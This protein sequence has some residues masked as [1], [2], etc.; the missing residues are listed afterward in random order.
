MEALLFES[1]GDAVA[2]MLNDALTR[3]AARADWPKGKPDADA[4]LAGRG[5][6]LT[7]TASS[8]S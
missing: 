3:K 1:G 4:P 2:A 6:R 8:P 5:R 7:R